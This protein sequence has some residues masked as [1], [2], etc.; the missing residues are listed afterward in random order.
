MTTTAGLMRWGARGCTALLVCAAIGA[1]AP[2]KP[3]TRI[4][5]IQELEDKVRK[6]ARQLVD[7]EEQ[8]A[9]VGRTIQELRGLEG[10]QRLDR[11]V[12][13]ARIEIERLSGGYDDNQDGI[14]DGV[15]VY[16]R[17]IDGDGDVIKAA[18]SAK[19]ELFDVAQKPGPKSVGK[20]ELSPDAMRK[21]WFS[22]V[23][24]AH[25]RIKVPWA[26]DAAASEHKNVTIAA[27]FTDL[28]TGQSFEA[29]HLAEVRKP[30]PSPNLNASSQP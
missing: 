19:V 24:S 13:V 8:L 30:A 1:C 27:R 23:L 11:I 9:S 3:D 25:Y 18:G 15:I 26:A 7:R 29:Q 4:T 21:V 17:L 16:V 12:H 2:E 10:P 22:K 6:Q 28:L 20:V 14:D 5:Q